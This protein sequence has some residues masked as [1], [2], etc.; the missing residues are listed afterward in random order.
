MIKSRNLTHSKNI[1]IDLKV[2]ERNIYDKLSQFNELIK[3]KAKQI[4]Q[5]N[6]KIILKKGYAIIRDNE[7][8]IVKNS[9]IAKKHDHLKIEMIDGY[10]DVH[11]KKKKT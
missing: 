4:D 8:R 3:L 9:I 5:S 6:P 2:I 7:H 10:I 11:R 1:E